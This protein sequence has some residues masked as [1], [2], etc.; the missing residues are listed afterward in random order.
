MKYICLLLLLL[1][2]LSAL[3]QSTASKNVSSFSIG[4]PQLDTIKKIWV[5]LPE[6]YQTSKE[7]YGV[8]YMHDAQNLFD[9]ETSFL[10]EWKVDEVLDS[11]EAQEIIVVGIEHGNEKR[12]AEL[13][14]FPHETHGGGEAAAYVDFIRENLK[15]HIDSTY[16]TLPEAGNTGIMGSSLGGLVSFYA[17]VKHPETFGH[18]GVF[19]PSF[20]FSEEIFR[21]TE[22]ADLD[23]SLRFYFLGGT[24][25]GEQMV[26]DLQRIKDL[27]L[28][29]GLP[30]KNMH[31]KIVEGGQHNEEFWSEHFP[32]AIQ[33]LFPLKSQIIL[34]L[35]K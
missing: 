31:I 27:L 4:A 23:P 25:E 19:S 34:Q 18:A 7:H 12:I 3:P 20:W 16:R 28:K 33:W 35:K 11:L 15:P 9:A 1:I 30:Q 6:A 21:F 10:G 5:Y 32:E 13:T 29:K 22:E 14:P 2:S 24:E 8:L 17:A 26:P